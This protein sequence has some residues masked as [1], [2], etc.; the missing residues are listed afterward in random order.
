MSKELTPDVDKTL[1]PETNPEEKIE[2]TK[3]EQETK[4]GLSQEQ[5]DEIVKT[6]LERE[7]AKILKEL[8][9]DDVD[10]AKARLEKA[11]QQEKTLQEKEQE[12]VLIKSGVKEDKFGEAL[13]LAALKA[14]MPLED[15]LKEV[16]AEYPTLA[17]KAQ[18]FGRKPGDDGESKKPVY[19]REFLIA[20]QHIPFYKRLLEEMN[21]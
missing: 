8:G 7:R 10:A 19:S 3:P 13:A 11:T 9:V 6:R 5:V 16:V 15:A 18:Q 1:T 4:T 14:D 17:G 12:I 21:K 20:N 2:G